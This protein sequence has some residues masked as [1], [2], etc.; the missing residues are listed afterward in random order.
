[1]IA[2]TDTTGLPHF[3]FV[4]FSKDGTEFYVVVVKAT[5]GL[6]GASA[7]S[8]SDE[9]RPVLFADEY[10]GVPGQ[11]SLRYE[12]DV[13]PC[14]PRVDI[15]VNGSA[16][17]PGHRD[18]R[19]SVELRAKQLHKTLLVSG[20]RVWFESGLGVLGATSATTI[21]RMPIVYE[22]A[23]GGPPASIAASEGCPVDQ[24]NPVGTG[25]IPLR[26]LLIG[27]RLPNIE[28]PD[29]AV[30]SWDARSR[31]AGLGCIGRS[32]QPRL[33]LAGT[34]DGIWKE[35]RFPFLP[36]DFQ[37]QYFQSAPEDQTVEAIDPG[38][39]FH[40]VNLHP[41]G[42]LTFHLPEWRVPI[43]W[44]RD[45]ERGETQCRLDT[46]LIEP[47]DARL[48]LTSRIHLPFGPRTNRLREVIVGPLSPG[49]GRAFM[50]GKRYRDLG[51][52]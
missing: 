45:Q 50:S 42:A 1:M 25:F 52:A 17:P 10:W 15:L 19:F 27:T 20:D 33:G 23:Y 22:R 32:W 34:Y 9:Q 12:S 38:E 37:D 28:Y 5:F 41:A 30:R 39:I 51:E 46:V 49:R 2:L 43:F 13:V 31:P 26:R 36:E 24:H 47:D 18:S 16:Y 8:L 6:A 44:R 48:V 11:S 40:L 3:G 29:S 14:K 21:T 7:P 4:A 35:N